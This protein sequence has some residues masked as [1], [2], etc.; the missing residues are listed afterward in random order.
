MRVANYVSPCFAYSIML[1][2]L[3][4]LL[5]YREIDHQILYTISNDLEPG[6]CHSDQQCWMRTQLNLNSHPGRFLN[7]PL[8]NL[9]NLI[10]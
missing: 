5:H 7:S 6:G 2:F 1:S 8:S 4:Q 10:L 3:G 9:D